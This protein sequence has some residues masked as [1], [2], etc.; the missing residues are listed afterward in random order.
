MAADTDC[1]RRVHAPGPRPAAARLGRRHC[2]RWHWVALGGTGMKHRRRAAADAR[3]VTLH[4]TPA[5]RRLTRRLLP[6]AERY[7]AVALAGFGAG[8][9]APVES[10]PVQVVGWVGVGRRIAWV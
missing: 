6:I 1:R 3:V 9:G 4:A 10:A 5:G 7:E 8:G 2:W